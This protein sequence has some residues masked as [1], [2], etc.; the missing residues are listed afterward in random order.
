MVVII[1][2]HYADNSNTR[3]RKYYTIIHDICLRCM[4][5]YIFLQRVLFSTNMF[6]TYNFT[7]EYIKGQCV[8]LSF[9]IEWAAF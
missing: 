8:R 6:L 9:Y 2:E 7:I 3:N 5:T 1:R 4:T